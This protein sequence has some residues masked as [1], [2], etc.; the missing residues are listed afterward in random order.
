MPY[1]DLKRPTKGHQDVYERP[2]KDYRE[3]LCKILMNNGVKMS[4]KVFV[5]FY[6][7]TL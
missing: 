6:G 3:S 4:L 2:N 7:K 5:R 1:K